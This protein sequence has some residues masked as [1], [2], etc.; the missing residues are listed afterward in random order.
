MAA[1]AA[2]L[3]SLLRWLCDPGR[4]LASER[5][6]AASQT[7][8]AK[9]ECRGMHAQRHQGWQGLAGGQSAS[10][11]PPVVVLHAAAPCRCESRL[12]T[13]LC[14]FLARSARPET[15]V[16]APLLLRCAL[17]GSLLQLLQPT[18]CTL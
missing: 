16:R 18:H 17:T 12:R 15:A 14:R 6:W 4:I 1:T 7:Q 8:R 5:G 11:F 9:S 3:P 2:P 10:L 13:L